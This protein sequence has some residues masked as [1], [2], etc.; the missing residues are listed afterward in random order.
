MSFEIEPIGYVSTEA[1]EVPRFYSISE[2]EGRLIIRDEYVEG[3]SDL[4]PG[5]EILVIFYFHRSPDFGTEHLRVIP[6]SRG[7]KRGVFSTR[8]PVRPNPLGLS[9]LEVLGIEGNT[10]HVRGLDMVD[11]SP[12]LDIKPRK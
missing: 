1:E 5:D 6:P 3:L 2:V 4:Q 11:G 12:V 9:Q 7:V 10:V 8:S